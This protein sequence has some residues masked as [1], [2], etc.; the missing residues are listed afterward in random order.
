MSRWG[1]AGLVV[2]AAV[3]S[4]A[5]GVWVGHR[6]GYTLG[7]RDAHDEGIAR[8]TV[9]RRPGAEL[10]LIPPADAELAALT[11]LPH[12]TPPPAFRAAIDALYTELIAQTARAYTTTPSQEA[13]AQSGYA[14]VLAERTGSDHYARLWRWHQ[15]R[16]RVPG[17]ALA[18][19]HH[20]VAVDLHLL[21]RDEACAV[22][23]EAWALSAASLPEAPVLRGLCTVVTKELVGP[24]G[25][26]LE[27]LALDTDVQ[28][29]VSEAHTRHTRAITELSTAEAQIDGVV[30]HDFESTVFAGWPIEARDRAV[31][32]VRGTGTVKA[33][34]ALHDAF[35]IAVLPEEDL[36]LVVLPRARI[37][38][39]SLV[40]QIAHESDG[41]WTKLTTEQRNQAIEA[42][43]EEVE[44]Q[45]H[46]DGLLTQAE[47]RAV[48]VV[49]DLYA[50]LTWLPGG[51]YR[52]EVRFAPSGLDRE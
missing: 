28:A 37:V 13:A 3:V 52:V 47:E 23:Q 20:P 4:L 43:R 21:L 41:W 5:L 42:L 44:A 12:A 25:E 16:H 7:V 38:S 49:A 51:G 45:A 46:R 50:P 34:F 15:G 19:V 33:G 22:V 24:W 48:A 1:T 27:A 39:N 2:G 18:L 40:P 8:R 10:G 29:A 35:E 32:E 30:R 9:P 31:I 14:A 26:A 11:E 17:T 6:Q 36:V